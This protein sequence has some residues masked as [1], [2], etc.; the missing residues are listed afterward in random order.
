MME[1][2]HLLNEPDVQA[3]LQAESFPVE[4]PGFSMGRKAGAIRALARMDSE[5]AWT[6]AEVCLRHGLNEAD[7]M[8]HVLTEIDPPRAVALL[9]VHV[10]D[11]WRPSVLWRTAWALRRCANRGLDVVAH[12][13][14]LIE[15][16]QP[17]VRRVGAEIAGVLGPGV[18]DDALRRMMVE[19]PEASV[20]EA[21]RTALLQQR[22]EQTALSLLE[23][24]RVATQE[25]VWRR[26]DAFLAIADP[27]FVTAPNDP[28]SL[29]KLDHAMAPGAWRHVCSWQEKQVEEL[30]SEAYRHDRDLE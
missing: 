25:N 8:P 2:L 23:A 27:R 3:F 19:D 11:E 9:C 6:A 21:C 15:D 13:T 26:L 28:L 17:N 18:L 12:V 20:R 14:R 30:A 29:A 1:C 24:L 5:L 7:Q 4:S 16:S 22:K 10:R